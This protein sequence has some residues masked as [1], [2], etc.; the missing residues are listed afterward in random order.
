MADNTNIKWILLILLGVIFLALFAQIEI[1]L[2]LN[3]EGIPITGQSFAVLL[4]AILFGR[5][6]GTLVVLIYLL[7]GALGLPVFAGG[8]SNGFEKLLG[9]SGGYLWGFL[10]AAFC[11]GILGEKGWR[12]S[13]P[14]AITAMLIGTLIILF[15]GVLRLSFKYG[16][17]EAIKIGLT[18]FVS[19]AAIKIALGGLCAH[20]I[21]QQ[22]DRIKA[23]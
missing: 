13:V 20:L 18:P 16:V 14:N 12:K 11:V 2:P 15:F 22:W 19:G 21:Q 23:G 8:T 17:G 1:V 3:E 5:W 7:L 6:R 4:M 9:G 10:P